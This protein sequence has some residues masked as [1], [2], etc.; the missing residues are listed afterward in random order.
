M[1]LVEALSVGLPVA[2][3]A[4][5]PHLEILGASYPFFADAGDAESLAHAI[6]KMLSIEDYEDLSH[7]SIKMSKKFTIE[8]M[9]DNYADLYKDLLH[10][11]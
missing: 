7:N 4:I 10:I 11:V 3:T 5:P 9:L 1:G 8:K 2:T 6:I